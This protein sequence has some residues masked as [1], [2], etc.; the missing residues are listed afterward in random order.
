MKQVT[1]CVINSVKDDN[2]AEA[3]VA[4]EVTLWEN[5]EKSWSGSGG[6]QLVNLSALVNTTFRNR[7]ST[8]TIVMT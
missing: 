6:E 2:V 5:G 7:A 8:P 3:H 4:G 1:V